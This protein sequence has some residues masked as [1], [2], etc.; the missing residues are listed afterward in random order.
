[1]R[2]DIVD[3]TTWIL[4]VAPILI[5]PI[6]L[7]PISLIMVKRGRGYNS[8]SR[9]G[10]SIEAQNFAARHCGKIL[11][12]ASIISLVLLLI[13]GGLGFAFLE[14]EAAMT[15]M[16]WITIAVPIVLAILPGI[17]TELATRRY[18]DRNGKPY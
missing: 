1:M 2:S 4:N 6:I 16:Y 12:R 5:L 17:F 14:N 15:I 3:A 11:F 8:F 7:M 13:C 18:F 9:A 10:A